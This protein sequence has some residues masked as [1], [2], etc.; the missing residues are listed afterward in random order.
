MFFE[1]NTQAGTQVL[2]ES[3]MFRFIKD[4]YDEQTANQVWQWSILAR[5]GEEFEL[6]A[7]TIT[8]VEF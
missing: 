2:K 5:N 6:A 8:A 7:H 1:I 3:N 4:L